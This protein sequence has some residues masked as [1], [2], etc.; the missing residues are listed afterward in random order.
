MSGLIGGS[1]YYCDIEGNPVPAQFV[2]I[3]L[4]QVTCW[5]CGMVWVPKSPCQPGKS[6]TV[7]CPNC[8]LRRTIAF[9]AKSYY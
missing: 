3:E 1:G 9:V 8:G 6:H 4:V 5:G 2:S 7:K